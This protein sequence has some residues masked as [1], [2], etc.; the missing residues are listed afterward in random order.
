MYK[1]IFYSLN[2]GVKCLGNKEDYQDAGIGGRKRR[3]VWY[4]VGYTQSTLYVCRAALCN[5]IKQKPKF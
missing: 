5:K 2:V 4:R 1:L 3:L